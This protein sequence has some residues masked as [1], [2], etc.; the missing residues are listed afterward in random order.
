VT[1]SRR[2]PSADGWRGRADAVDGARGL[3]RSPVLAASEI[4][5]FAFCPQ[6]WY[7]Q[8]RRL[9]VTP[10]A[11]RRRRAGAAAH[12]ALGRQTDFLGVA[13]LA[14]RLLLVAIALLLVLVL[15]LLLFLTGRPLVGMP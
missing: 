11:D 6:A 4:G 7:L 1:A 9:P 15:F 14:R 2:A 8:R 3:D 12:R 10:Q 5:S 13:A